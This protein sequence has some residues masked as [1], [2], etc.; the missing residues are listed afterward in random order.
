MRNLRSI[1]KLAYPVLWITLVSLGCATADPDRIRSTQSDETGWVEVRTATGFNWSEAVALMPEAV[2]RIDRV[3]RNRAVYR[4]D[5]FGFGHL[6]LGSGALYPYHAHA[7]PEA[8]H[9]LSGVAEW[10]VDGETRRVG[11]GTTI[12]HAPYADHRWTTVSKEP[13]RVVWAQWVP[14]G[15]RSGMLSDAVR[16][17]GAS[18]TGAFLA[19]ETRSISILPTRL[20]APVGEAGPGSVFDEMK[21]A[22][23]RAR[24]REASRPPIRAFVDAV[25]VPWNTEL[26]GLRWRAVFGTPD[27]EWGH[28]E[29]RGPGTRKIPASAVPW[30]LHVLSGDARIEAG[31]DDAVV[32]RAG[33]SVVIQPGELVDV[34]FEEAR[35]GGW[36]E[37]A[38][39]RAF[40]VRWTP[41][42]DL[43]YWARDYFL[44]EPMPEPPAG[45]TLPKDVPFFE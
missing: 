7:S 36:D 33:T 41:E 11:P 45:A 27:L 44:V 35:Q 9:V 28:V 5:G 31:D 1:L 6:M 22:R 12:Y 14:D 37:V 24:S 8:Y 19:G 34:R 26:P 25:G 3:L 43:G 30:L 39:L 40:W 4:Q 23:T 18:S 21:K 16:R 20:S 10:S 13:L 2:D 42:G 15:D 17:R 32:A 29:V 38:P